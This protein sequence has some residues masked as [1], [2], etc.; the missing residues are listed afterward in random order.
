L[1]GTCLICGPFQRLLQV[2]F[3]RRRFVQVRL[4]L[5]PAEQAEE[6]KLAQLAQ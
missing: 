1:S 5:F 2:R 4:F 3:P 6:V